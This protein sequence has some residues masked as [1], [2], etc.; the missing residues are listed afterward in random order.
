MLPLH[1]LHSSLTHQHRC[2]QSLFGGTLPWKVLP[3]NSRNPVQK[4]PVH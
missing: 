2:Q 4:A 3:P 1:N